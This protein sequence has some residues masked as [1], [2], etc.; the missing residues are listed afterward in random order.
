VSDV[1]VRTAWEVLLPAGTQLVGGEAGLD[2]PVTWPVVLRTHPPAFDPLRGGELAIVP[3]DRLHLLD[4]AM[5]LGRVV[6]QLARTRIGAVCAI[7]PVADDAVSAADSVGVPLFRLPDGSS[8]TEVHQAFMRSLAEHRVQLS[9]R[10]G[11]IGRELTALAIDGR[12]R[13]AIVR[14]AGQL[15]DVALAL[16]DEV[17][18]PV[19]VYAPPGG[20]IDRAE[21]GRLLGDL[22][23]SM[24]PADGADELRRHEELLVGQRVSLGAR[25]DANGARPDGAAVDGPPG[26]VLR[27][28]VSRARLPAA[29]G[30][31]VSTLIAPVWARFGLAGRLIMLVTGRDL[32][33]LDQ[34]ILEQAVAA[35]AIDLAREEAASAARDELQG[36]FLDDLLAGGF[37]SDDAIERRGRNLGY[38]LTQPHAVLAVASARR[39]GEVVDLIRRGDAEASAAALA[40]LLAGDEAVV[41]PVACRARGDVL[42]A[43]VPIGPIAEGSEPMPELARRVLGLWDGS[44]G[45]I[46]GGEAGPSVGVGGVAAGGRAIAEAVGRTAQAAAIGARLFGP[47]TATAFEDL[48][49]YRLLFGLR[50]LDEVVG[51]Y[52]E[53]LGRLIEHD[54][55]TG[56]E[57][58]RTLDAY[59]S[60][61]CSPTAAAERLHLHRNGLLYRLQRIREILPVSLDDP[62][63]RLALHLALRIGDVLEPNGSSQVQRI[64]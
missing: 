22:P 36:D 20:R 16:E 44:V 64:A 35:C 46:W 25:G 52:H 27:P 39:A 17:G 38:E 29:G 9:Q 13:A 21:I 37:P 34:A 49:L 2:R 31:P 18:R 23:A 24:A 40:E 3:L 30:P 28:Q 51:F 57:L 10:I 26:R 32:V 56:G 62:E 6:T 63:R 55:R 15:A 7:G 41:G 42:I 8:A 59:L 4:S 60:V 58:V 47:G 33:G 1:S 54:R 19:V 53:M 45:A 50:G 48:G 43:L 5:T 14:R 12:G 61:G 11:D